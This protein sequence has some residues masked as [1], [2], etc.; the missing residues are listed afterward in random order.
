[1]AL[2]PVIAK[3]G[4][5][6]RLGVI[7]GGEGALIAGAHRTAIHFDGTFD[8]V[9][10]VLSRDPSKSR[11]QARQLGIARSYADV[12]DML[13]R[14]SS[15]SEPID[16][17]AI[18]TPNDSH[19]VIAGAALDAGIHVIC[20]KPIANSLAEARALKKKIDA[21]KLELC[22][23]H[24]YSGYP[25]IRQAREMVSGGALGR[26]HLVEV[27]YAQG[28]LGT[29]VEAQPE[30]MVKQL[31]WRLD[32]KQGG[33]N[34]LLLD[35]GTHSQQLVS[36]VL[37][38]KFSKVSAHL[39]AIDPRRSFSDTATVSAELAGGVHASMF[40]TKAATGAPHIFTINV[41]GDKAGLGWEQAQPQLLQIYRQGK[42]T[43]TLHRG[44][45]ALSQLARRSIRAPEPHPEG[46]REA[47]ANIY[48]DF[49]ERVASRIAGVAPDPLAMT[50]PTIEDGI[51]SLAFVEA[52]AASHQRQAPVDLH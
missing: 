10:A 4:R 31:V 49:A 41:Y 37:S 42:P 32:P 47:F 28:N 30:S 39:S 7:G 23:T 3:L 46:F 15:Q 8:I 19:A 6:L 9:A 50:M 13:R 14:E 27:R 12:A 35:V 40:I 16:A 20:D 29:L 52:C 1:M 34:H 36:Y 44:A 2:N 17:I 18:M 22:V 43:E 33:E 25:M 21:S 45:D 11:D 38:R 48:T 26:V 5:K 51:D 24:N